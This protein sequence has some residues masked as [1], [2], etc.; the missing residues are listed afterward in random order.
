MGESLMPAT[1]WLLD[2]LGAREAVENAGFI[3]KYGAEFYDQRLD[4]GHAFYFLRDR[5]WPN[6]SYEV[7]RAEFDTILLDNARKHGVAVHQPATVEAVAFDATGATLGITS[8][9]ERLGVR[10]AF[11]VDASGRDGFLATRIGR[12][13]RLPNLGK[14]ALFG[15]FR[16]ARR[17]PGQDEGNIHIY[18]CD[19]G[20]LWWIPLAGDVTS[21]GAVM[22]GRTVRAW[23]GDADGLFAHMVSRCGVV[24]EGLQ[25]AARIGA[26]HHAAS[27]AYVNTPVVG[28]RHLMI[29]DAIAFTDPIFS[30]GV[31]IAMRSGQLAAEAI[32]R[33]FRDGR[34]AARRFRGYERELWRGIRPFF[35]FIHKYYEPAFFELFLSPNNLFGMVDGVLAVLS[36]GAFIKLT[37]HTRF[38]LALLFTI[39]RVHTFVRKLQGRPVESRLEW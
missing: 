24:A 11:V 8:E 34:F 22:H 39:G 7:P 35:K 30:G 18:V 10:A 6:Y 28:D 20:W 15:H 33:A 31:F 13:D 37:W 5:P 17:F 36:G 2:K 14:V 3:K 29:G 19:E 1:M 27:F 32:V 23:T 26:L 21:V 4:K 12:R 16:G 38:S 9:G 25:S